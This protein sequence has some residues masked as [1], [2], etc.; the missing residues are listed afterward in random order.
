MRRRLH[1]LNKDFGWN[2]HHINATEAFQ[3][4]TSDSWHV[5]VIKPSVDTVRRFLSNDTSLATKDCSNDG[6]ETRHAKIGSFKG[7]ASGNNTSKGNA[8]G[9][10]CNA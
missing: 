7:H 8:T 3:C 9:K 2:L 5:K 10:E 4:T 1:R 6:G